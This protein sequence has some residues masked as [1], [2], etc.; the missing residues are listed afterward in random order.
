MFRVRR[1]YLYAKTPPSVTVLLVRLR[2]KRKVLN[3]MNLDP[4]IRAVQTFVGVEPD[5]SP[6]QITW[7]AIYVKLT[8][9]AWPDLQPATDP[10]I[11]A[12]QTFVGVEP[13]GSPGQ[14]TWKAIYAK[15]T[16]K[17]WV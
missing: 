12:V 4:L 14:I 11:R 1:T 7:K 10:L 8:G 2:L 17:T 6:G 5:G 13:D 15:L 9:K 3:I 16:G